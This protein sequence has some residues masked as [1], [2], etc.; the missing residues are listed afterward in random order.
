MVDAIVDSVAVVV[1]VATK[2]AV[3]DAAAAND[4]RPEMNKYSM[5]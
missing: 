4:Y 2:T 5:A 1:V 3:V